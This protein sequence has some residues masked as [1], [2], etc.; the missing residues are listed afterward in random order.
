MRAM[1][2]R[3]ANTAQTTGSPGFLRCRRFDETLRFAG[4]AAKGVEYSAA[5][6]QQ[7]MDQVGAHPLEPG[8]RH[9]NRECQA[10]AQWVDEG[11]AHGADAFGMLFI[12]ESHAAFGA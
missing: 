1:G 2:G 12:V 9:R 3:A 11:S 6:A 5:C 7:M 4:A 8:G 10:A